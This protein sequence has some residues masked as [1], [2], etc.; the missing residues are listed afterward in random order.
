[1]ASASSP[2]TVENNCHE[3]HDEAQSG[4][5]SVVLV[6]KHSRREG[7]EAG[8]DRNNGNMQSKDDEKDNMHYKNWKGVS[9]PNPNKT[10]PRP[11]SEISGT[12][13]EPDKVVHEGVYCDECRV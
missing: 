10:N 7:Q 12:S 5:S 3:K 9:S 13:K 11:T 6:E 1:M 4:S 2:P 8:Y